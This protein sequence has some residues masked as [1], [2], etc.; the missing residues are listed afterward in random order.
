MKICNDLL[1]NDV[2][3][4]GQLKESESVSFCLRERRLLINRYKFSLFFF[5]F[6]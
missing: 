5:H 1:I 4:S 2:P 3:A 6:E